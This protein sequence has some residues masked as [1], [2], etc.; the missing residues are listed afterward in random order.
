M[1][2][3]L[4]GIC[5][6]ILSGM[7]CLFIRGAKVSLRFGCAGLILGSVAGIIPALNVLLTGNTI[8]LKI[9]WQV[10][11]GSFY[12]ELDGL[13]ALFLILVLL[14]CSAAA[15]YGCGYMLSY[16]ERRLGIP[17]FFFNLLA[18][19][20]AMVVMARNSILFLAA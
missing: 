18:A 4:S 14:L 20:M 5:L 13:S 7:V 16:K 17:T 1:P 12:I 2:I 10:P 11:Y 8:S 3:I 15:V 9:P 19:S 6:I